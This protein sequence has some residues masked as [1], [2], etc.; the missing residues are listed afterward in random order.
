VSRV[1][2]RVTINGTAEESVFIKEADFVAWTKPIQIS[3]TSTRTENRVGL[4]DAEAAQ[5]ELEPN[6]RPRR[7]GGRP[8]KYDWHSFVRELLRIANTPD[9]LPPRED[10]Q[11]RMLDWCERNWETSPAD[12]TVRGYIAS[13]YP[14]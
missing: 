4:F 14:A 2:G 11:R 12:S 6:E 3:P 5:N 9:G 8:P 10:L 1:D 7:Q 13:L